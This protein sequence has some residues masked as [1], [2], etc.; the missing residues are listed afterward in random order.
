VIGGLYSTTLSDSSYIT[1][2]VAGASYVGG[3]VGVTDSA[4]II[5]GSFTARPVTGTYDYVGGLVGKLAGTI[6][7]SDAAAGSVPANGTKYSYAAGAVTGRNDVG[8][9][10]GRAD[11]SA[12]IY[13]AYATGAVSADYNYG[14]LVGFVTPGATLAN[15]HYNIDAVSITGLTPASP[16]TR[17]A[18]TGLITTGGLFGAQYTDWFT[19]ALDGLAASNT[20][21][22]ASY[23]GGPDASGYYSLTSSTDVKNYLATPIKSH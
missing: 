21:K 19:P 6:Q 7:A 13:N 11:T 9:L 22:L 3:L 16:S 17:V 18:V 5:K 15:A 20:T 10:V 1:G 2:T 12:Y 14:G 23:F 8:G 4:A